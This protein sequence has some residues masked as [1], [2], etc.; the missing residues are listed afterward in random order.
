L[1]LRNEVFCPYCPDMNT[2]KSQLKN[3]GFVEISVD[4]LTEEWKNF[5]AARVQQ[6]QSEKIKLL[7]IH[8]E[9][10]YNRLLSFYTR[11]RDL[12]SM[13]NLGGARFLAKK[14]SVI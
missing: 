10:T 4:E 13:G 14:P 9:D 1:I 11:I 3:A 7:A 8:R 12:Y 5:T 6:W 2:Y